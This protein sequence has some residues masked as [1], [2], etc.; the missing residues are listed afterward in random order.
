[1][2]VEMISA[3]DVGL[4]PAEVGAAGSPTWVAGVEPVEIVRRGEVLEGE[5]PVALARALGDRLRALGALD[6][7]ADASP[8]LPPQAA[9]AGAAI[10]VVVE[11]SRPVTQE[12]LAKAAELAVALDGPVEAIVIGAGA[13]DA[14]ALARA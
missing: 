5:D 9:R 1:K 4:S 6:V 2:P 3:A 7:G 8:P 14:D 13:P 12:L 10:W 11:E